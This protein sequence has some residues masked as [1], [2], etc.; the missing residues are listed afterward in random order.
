M[1]NIERI[2]N[3][4]LEDEF[5]WRIP[6]VNTDTLPIEANASHIYDNINYLNDVFTTIRESCELPYKEKEK[7]TM[8]SSKSTL[9]MPEIE[10]YN[11][12]VPNK[13]VEVIFTDGE[14]IK[15][16]CHNEDTFKV[17]DMIM[18]AMLKKAMGSAGNF[19]NYMKRAVRTWN[20]MI[21]CERKEKEEAERLEKKREKLAEKS[22]R[23]YEKRKARRDEEAK[24]KKQAEIDEQIH[25]Q[26]QAYI[27]AMEY[28]ESKKTKK[29]SKKTDENNEK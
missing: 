24:A 17:E 18:V 29:K 7:P 4:N 20:A 2:K 8:L 10:T 27:K 14:V 5:E 16:V 13:V 19:N 11:V 3:A 6:D 15:T 12:V 26:T 1:L 28:M 22:K 23:R 9:I 21:E 25:I